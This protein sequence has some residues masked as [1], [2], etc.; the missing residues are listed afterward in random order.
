MPAPTTMVR[1]AQSPS[2]ARMLM[3]ASLA[4]IRGGSCP[5]SQSP[6]PGIMPFLSRR[7]NAG[8]A[9]LTES[10]EDFA[11]PGRA[12]R[13]PG[14]RAKT[15]DLHSLLPWVQALAPATPPLRP[16]HAKL[17]TQ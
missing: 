9:N 5:P 12:K 3:I 14:P 15:R 8:L 4:P 10:L 7:H 11:C 2:L 1:A 16:G 13:D 17:L 6:L